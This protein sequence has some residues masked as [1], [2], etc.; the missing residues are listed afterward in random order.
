[1]KIEHNISTTNRINNEQQMVC[2]QIIILIAATNTKVT[3]FTVLHTCVGNVVHSVLLNH[4]P[5][6]TYIHAHVLY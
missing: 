3:Y 4:C 5:S 6:H 1:M 2:V